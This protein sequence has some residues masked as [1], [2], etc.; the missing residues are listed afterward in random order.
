MDISEDILFRARAIQL[1][2]FEEN[3]RRRIKKNRLPLRRSPL[4]PV[5]ISSYVTASCIISFATSRH[6]VIA[7]LPHRANDFPAMLNNASD[8]S[9]S[10]RPSVSRREDREEFRPGIAQDRRLARECA[11]VSCEATPRIRRFRKCPIF[12]IVR[13]STLQTPSR[14][15]SSLSRPFSL[16]LE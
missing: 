15:S 1:S 7:L 11:R 16:S 14:S 6:R 13:K 4:L 3:Y 2:P 12:I 8:F 9:P 10:K 5:A